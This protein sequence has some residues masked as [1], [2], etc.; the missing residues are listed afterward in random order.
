MKKKSH[1]KI[2]FLGDVL[3]DNCMASDLEKYREKNSRCYNFSSLYS[4]AFRDLLKESDYVSANLETP[5]S[6]NNENLTNRQWEFCSPIEFAKALFDAGV[7][8]V[9][10]ANN[11]CLDRGVSG[12]KDTV[13]ALKK[14]GFDYSGICPEGEKRELFISQTTGLKLGL[15]SYTYGTNAFSNKKYLSFAQR[16]C[17]DLIQEQEQITFHWDLWKRYALKRPNSFFAKIRRQ[18]ILFLFPE[19]KDKQIYEQVSCGLY[20]RHLIKKDLKEI[21]K[22]HCD[23]IVVNLHIGGQYNKEPSI[24]TQRAIDFLLKNGADIV[25]GNHE[26]VIHGCNWRKEENKFLCYSLGNCIGSAGLKEP[27]FDRFADFSIAVH[28][29]C[30]TKEKKIDKVSFSVLKVICDQNGKYQ[31]WPACELLNEENFSESHILRQ[32]TLNA[33]K[34]FSGKVYNRVEKEFLL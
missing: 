24:F 25:I 31:I 3:C 13:L 6:C 27:P 22:K 10:T 15:L 17:V 7:H 32:A 4:Q 16:R 23:W 30:N 14:I 18:L 5:I 28:L 29:Y 20:R 2:T 34:L 8:Y 12:L 11:H 9:A 33:A 1:I 26:H 19:N 21:K